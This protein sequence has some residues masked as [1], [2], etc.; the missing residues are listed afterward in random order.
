[1]PEAPDALLAA[2]ET[3][4]EVF[5]LGRPMFAGMPQSPNHPEFR[6]ALQRRHGDV[7]RADG[8]SA[9]NEVIVTGGH[10]GT[11]LDALCHV[12]FEG[13]L[14]G[15]LDADDAQRGGRF[16]ALG[17]ET[18]APFVCRAVLLDVPRALGLGRCAPAYEIT[19]EDLEACASSQARPRPGDVVLIRTGWG[20]LFDD[21]DAYI[22]RSSGVPGPGEAA[23]RWLAATSPRAVGDDTIAFERLAPGAGHALLPAHRVLL[24]EAGVHIVEMLDLERLAAAGVYEFFF[25]MAPLALVGATGS[26][27]RPLALAARRP[28]SASLR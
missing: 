28:G 1:M 3:G 22:G 19:P 15:G 8:S 16:A 20:Q 13:R 17:V 14:Y 27:V 18:V 6:L 5:D 24:V 9:A 2:L 25:V 23:A 10:V 26:P 12:S 7:V 4:I 11:H 21:R